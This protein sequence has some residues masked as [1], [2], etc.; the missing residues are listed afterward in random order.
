MNTAE[1]SSKEY[2]CKICIKYYSSRQNLWRHNHTFHD[3]EIVKNVKNNLTEK[4]EIQ[5]KNDKYNCK[6]CKSKFNNINDLDS[7][8]K[9]KCKPNIKHN[10]VFKFNTNTFGKNKYPND[11][12]GE[13]YIIQTDFSL[14]GYYKIGVTTNLYHRMTSYRCGAVIEPRIHCYFP[15]KDIKKSD[16]LMK[17]KLLKYNIKREIYKIDNLAEVTKLLKELQK[18]MNSEELEVLPEIKNCDV[19]EC[20][21]C[22]TIC[23][24]NYEL[25][26][27]LESCEKCNDKFSKAANDQ[28]EELKKQNELLQQ[29]IKENEIKIR[30]EMREEIAAMKKQLLSIMNKQCKVHPKTLQ[31]IN[32]TLNNSCN[33]TNNIINIVQLGNENLENVFSKNKQIEILKQRYGCLPYLIREAH[34]N[35]KYPQFKNIL[36]TNLQNNIAYKYDKT[37]KNFIAVDKSDLLNEVVGARMD[38]IESFFE[39]NTDVLDEKTKNCVEQFISKMDSREGAYYDDKMKDVKL[40]IYNNRDKVSKELI[41]TLEIII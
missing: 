18:E 4:C 39:S 28:T 35:D 22:N 16:S 10:N 14:K 26:I 25:K 29:Q 12:G 15:I 19:V 33:T 23:T 20:K 5:Q 17:K 41:Q 7:H 13:I 8:I 36:I 34:L 40:M 30:E 32:N 27:H 31:K 11:N 9:L 37:T 1:N 2:I 21:Y 3:S 6:E 24:S 38:D